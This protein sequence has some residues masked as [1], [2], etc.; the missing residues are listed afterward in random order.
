[1]IIHGIQA[2]GAAAGQATLLRRNG[3]AVLLL[4]AAGSYAAA[5]PAGGEPGLPGMETHRIEE[6]VF[7]GRV[8]VYEAGRG[9]GRAILLV[10]GIG[11]DGARDYSDQIAWLRES[12]HVIALDL[13]GFGQSDKS[14]ALYTPANYVGVLKHVADRFL[15]RPFVLVGHSLGALVSLRYAATYPGDV[16]KLVVMSVPGV[17]HRHATTSRYLA[18]LMG[19]SPSEFESLSWLGRLPGKLLTP[20]ERL[21]VDP[22][23]VLADPQHREGLLNGD[24]ANIAGLAAAIDDLQQELPSVQAET[25]IIWGGEDAIAPLRNGR[26]LARTLSRA[27]LE[28]IEDAAHTPMMETPGRLR[29]VLEPFLEHGLPAPAPGPAA[30]MPQNGEA[31]CRR[32]RDRIFEGGFDVLVLESC[33]NVR[34]RNARVRAL[35]ILSST[36]TIDDSHIGGGRTGMLVRSSTVVMTGGRIEGTVAISAYASR[37]DLAAVDLEGREAAVKAMKR[38]YV[39]FSLS[40]LKS[41]YTEGLMHDFVTVTDRNP[42]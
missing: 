16:E 30:V 1:V 22:Y 36:V 40:R 8:A 28:V 10:H 39:V 13:P 4:V 11:A 35:R 21:G 29:T 20:L 38:S 3:I 41:P 33:H 26:V 5:H 32:E 23:G 34:I 12:F 18:G 17:L 19:V 9:K 24:P 14:D 7:N 6:P 25:L 15:Q 37:L 42:R 2:R 31:R 27:R